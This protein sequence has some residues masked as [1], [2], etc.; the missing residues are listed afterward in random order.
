MSTT[1]TG[2]INSTFDRLLADPTRRTVEM[3]EMGKYSTIT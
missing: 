3:H 2:R 1:F